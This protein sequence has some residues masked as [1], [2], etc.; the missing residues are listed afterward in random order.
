MSVSVSGSV[1]VRDIDIVYLRCQSENLPSHLKKN[2]Q[3]S[4]KVGIFM[5]A[6]Q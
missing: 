5:F 1:N 4:P 3:R 2:S 6:T